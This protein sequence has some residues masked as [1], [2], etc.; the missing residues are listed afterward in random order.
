[1]EYPV[2]L[3][4]LLYLNNCYVLGLKPGTYWVYNG[5][6]QRLSYLMILFASHKTTQKQTRFFE[7]CLNAYNF[8]SNK[9]G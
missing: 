1:M 6:S 8:R 3:S 7:T 5:E 2:A 4:T 9:V